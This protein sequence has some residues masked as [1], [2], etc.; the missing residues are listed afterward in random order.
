M[1]GLEQ[2]TRD[3]LLGSW[4]GVADG[5]P[6]DGALLP[7]PS[8]FSGQYVDDCRKIPLPQLENNEP[9]V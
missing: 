6:C 3:V 5:V 7:R 2:G 1:E 4:A 9:F 8:K